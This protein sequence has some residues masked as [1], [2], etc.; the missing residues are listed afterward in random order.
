[1]K[2]S[3]SSDSCVPALREFP[4]IYIGRIEPANQMNPAADKGIIRKRAPFATVCIE[5]YDGA[6]IF[7]FGK[8]RERKN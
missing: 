1:M 5:A 6:R 8:G 4:L 2:N 3:N 7:Y